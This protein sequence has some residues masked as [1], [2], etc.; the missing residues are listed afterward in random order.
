MGRLGLCMEL[1]VFMVTV[2]SGNFFLPPQLGLEPA[3]HTSEALE[4]HQGLSK[5]YIRTFAPR[6]LYLY[7]L[8]TRNFLPMHWD[9]SIIWCFSIPFYSTVSRMRIRISFFL[10]P[11]LL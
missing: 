3:P 8:V 2:S 10:G 11:T 7:K 1:V 4:T 9:S 5:W 6:T